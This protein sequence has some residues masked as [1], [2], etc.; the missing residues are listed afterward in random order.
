[1]GIVPNMPSITIVK[2][3]TYRNAQEEFSNTYHFAGTTPAN[4]ADWKTLA[5]GI[6]AAEKLTVTVDVKFH[7]AYGYVAG[8]NNSVA[9]IDYDALGGTLIAG[10]FT[11]SGANAQGDSAAWIRWLTPNLS[12]RG[13]K[14]YLRKYMHG[15]LTSSGGGDTLLASQR[16]ALATYGAKLIDGTLPSSFVMTG[17]QGASAS[18]PVVSVFLTTRTLKRRGKRPP[19]V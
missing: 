18:A 2:S 8:N 4:A 14:I 10:T 19:T 3:F 13:K 16:T 11:G 15:M 5:D 12:T 17:P 6:I 9:Q 1:M 7:R